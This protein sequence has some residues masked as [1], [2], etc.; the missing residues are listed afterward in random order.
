MISKQQQIT[1]A[2]LL[3][4]VLSGCF[5]GSD[6]STTPPAHCADVSTALAKKVMQQHAIAS[7]PDDL[8]DELAQSLE[9][10]GRVCL[11]APS[12]TSSCNSGGARAPEIGNCCRFTRPPEGLLSGL[13]AKL[14][15]GR[16]AED[17]PAVDLQL[18]TVLADLAL[19]QRCQ[20][21]T[22]TD[23][24]ASARPQIAV[25]GRIVSPTS[26]TD[27]EVLLDLDVT[28]DLTCAAAAAV[29]S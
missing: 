27:I 20:V 22:C 29:A 2:A 21:P 23:D 18:H 11:S 6:Q 28:L 8:K 15:I 14:R 16:D 19:D 13:P 26:S 17:Q 25:T 10:V 24:R 4:L 1:Q 3:A 9:S 5:G 7:L 12:E